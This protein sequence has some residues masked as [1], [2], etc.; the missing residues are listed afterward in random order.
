[1]EN[2]QQTITASLDTFSEE[3]KGNKRG[4]EARRVA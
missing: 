4:T 2:F 3:K 1:M